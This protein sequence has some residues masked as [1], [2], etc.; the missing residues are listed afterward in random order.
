MRLKVK[1]TGQ[2]LH[3]SEQF[4][5]V[6]TVEGPQ[7]LAVNVNTVIGS[8]ID[9]GQPIAE[10]GRSCLIELPSETSSGAWRVWVDQAELHDDVPE[11]AE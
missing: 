6:S 11:A 10:Q 7:E 1:E 8:S 4:I 2:G 9:I 5:T 3:P